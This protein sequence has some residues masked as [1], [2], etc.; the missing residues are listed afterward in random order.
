MQRLLQMAFDFLG[1]PEPAGVPVPE[2]A[3]RAQR[4]PESAPA[5]PMA[6]VFQPGTWHHPRANRMVRL[7]SC[8]VAYEFKRGK[9]R[10]IGLSVGPDGLS[11]SAPR[12][13]PL[14][15][16]DALL[17]H[18]ADWVLEKLQHAHQR[19]GELARAR[20]V[21][22]DGAE[23]DFL[24]QRLRVALDPTHS[25]AQVG[26]LLEP[27]DA[28]ALATLRLGLA[29]NAGEAQ[30][31]DAAQAWLMRQ[32]KRVFTE[33]LDHF[34]PLLGVRY[35]VLRLSSAGTRWGSASA[36]GTIRLNWRLIHLKM[37]MVDYVV[38]HELSHLH[39]MDHSPQFWDVV[40]RVMPDHTER[41]RALKRA[42]VPLGE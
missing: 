9:R 12:W 38:V 28:G 10:T 21:W 18:K 4:E 22:A 42:A 19:A 24:G 13:T 32:A 16:V 6:Q 36:D 23:L 5:E 41:R 33:R 17:R 3:P 2:P 1:G 34:A 11:V 39:H 31:R 35:K 15:E 7:D 20:T 8:E 14:G 26:A 37:E 40:A 27:G 29:R 30:I 25:F